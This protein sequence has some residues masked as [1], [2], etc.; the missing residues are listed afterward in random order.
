V[1][2]TCAHPNESLGFIQGGEFF[3]QLSNHQLL[4]DFTVSGDGTV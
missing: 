1:E 4:K 3:D 2:G